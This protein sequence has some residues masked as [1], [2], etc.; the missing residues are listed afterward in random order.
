MS[1]LQL[2]P[3]DWLA[4]K[5]ST[6]AHQC[7][8]GREERMTFVLELCR[9]QVDRETGGPFAAAVFDRNGGQ[10][11]GA[12]VNR[13]EAECCSLLHAE[14]VALLTAQQALGHWNLATGGRDCELVSSAAPCAMCLGAIPW[15]GVRS[16]VCAAR[17]EDVR[18]IGFEEGCKPDPWTRG[19]TAAGIEVH[20]DV[21]RGAAAGI[22]RSYAA[23]GG[24]IYNG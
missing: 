12:G 7:F 19:L 10:L 14:M 16:L 11:L 13:V 23:Q 20:E 9:E 2:D 18:A 6:V 17:D 4:P 1:S 22:L 8:A 21:Q 3:P 15:S 24:C 5:L